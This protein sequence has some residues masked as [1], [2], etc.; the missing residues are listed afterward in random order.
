MD[1]IFMRHG[2]TLA[3]ENGLLA[4]VSDIPLS[5]KG[6]MEAEET[7]GLLREKKFQS[8]YCSPLKRASQ[9][10]ELMDL[11]CNYDQRL[12]EMNFG[13]FEGMT[14]ENMMKRY[15]RETAAWT[16]NYVNYRIPGGESLS[17]V[18]DRTVSFLGEIKEAQGKI[19][20]VTHESVIKCA[21]CSIL[22]SIEHFYRF[23]ADHCRF[24]TVA[25]ENNYKYIKTIN[26]ERIY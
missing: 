18:Y 10:A 13:I 7:A 24:T 14:Y 2:K 26:S 11:K 16:D 8:V 9:T 3:N 12:M 20:V 17:E 23:K 25:L 15:P 1:I 19:L 5:S 4:G 6:I 22:G 21:L